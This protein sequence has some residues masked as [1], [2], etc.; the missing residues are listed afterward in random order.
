MHSSVS[1]KERSSN[2]ELYRIIVMLLIVMHHYVVN[3]GVIQEV[4]NNPLAINSIYMSL[5]GLWGKTG[6]N[7]FVMITGWFMCTSRITMQ[8]ILKLLLQIYFYRI[9]LD[10]V[11]I[12]AGY[13]EFSFQRLLPITGVSDGFTSCFILFFLMIPFLNALIHSLTK[14][15]HAWLVV[16]LLSIYTLMGSSRIIHVTFNYTTWFSVLYILMSYVR[17]YGIPSRISLKK[18]KTGGVRRL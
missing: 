5:F 4:E 9:V 13:A 17:F 16:L 6:I 15:Q 2:L 7:C 3:S 14:R 1:K 11:F 18:V 10:T 8:K 12:V